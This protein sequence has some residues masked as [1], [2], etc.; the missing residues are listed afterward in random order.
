MKIDP[1]IASLAGG[2]KSKHD[3][4]VCKELLYVRLSSRCTFYS[5]DCIVAT[6]EADPESPSFGDARKCFAHLLDD[7]VLFGDFEVHY[8]SLEA[9]F[10]FLSFFFTFKD[11]QGG[12]FN[13]R[14][15]DQSHRGPARQSGAS[16][17]GTKA[18][19]PLQESRPISS[20]QPFPIE[21]SERAG[22]AAMWLMLPGQPKRGRS[23]FQGGSFCR[24]RS[25]KATDLR[26]HG[27]RAV[28]GDLTGQT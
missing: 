6:R 28:N 7:D 4:V 14:G 11:S 26:C 25:A 15:L 27:S 9:A 12:A 1:S 18:D 10:F 2:P 13:S 16:C 8:R 20:V 17:K 19:T 24:A 22:E 21:P 5:R 23:P 3:C